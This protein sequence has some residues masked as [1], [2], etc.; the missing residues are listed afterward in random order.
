MVGLQVIFSSILFSFFLYFLTFLHWTLYRTLC[1]YD[2]SWLQ[3]TKLQTT[4][5]RQWL[6]RTNVWNFH[7]F[8]FMAL[9]WPLL[10]SH[11]ICIQRRKGN[12]KD[13]CLS[14][15]NKSFPRDS[16]TDWC[17][18]GQ[19]DQYVNFIADKVGLENAAG[20][21][22]LPLGF[23]TPP[24]WIRPPNPSCLPPGLLGRLPDPEVWS[25]ELVQ[26]FPNPP[27]NSYTRSLEEHGKWWRDRQE[28]GSSTIPSWGG[29]EDSGTGLPCLWE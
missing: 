11:H 27:I 1:R 29:C 28:R 26:H 13:Q 2:C 23:L 8:S 4:V 15:E 20:N 3:V 18:I 21:L 22:Q 19:I 14:Q 16:T 10:P 25:L 24:P 9:T 5:V 6:A 7:G 17:L 12:Q